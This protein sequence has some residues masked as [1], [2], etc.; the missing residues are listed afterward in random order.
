MQESKRPVSVAITTLHF[1]ERGNG[2]REEYTY[3][4]T[5]SIHKQVY[6][7]VYGTEGEEGRQQTTLA[8]A[9][10][11]PHEIALDQNGTVNAHMRFI[12]GDVFCTVYRVAGVGSMDMEICARSVQHEETKH[13]WKIR[14]DYEMTVGGVRARRVMTISVT[15]I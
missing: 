13:G 15:H 9:L 4:G 6:T 14:L 10:D 5:L 8:F 3:A 1:D 7:L 12:P 2:E 11:R